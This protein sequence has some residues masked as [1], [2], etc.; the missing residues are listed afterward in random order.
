ME[1]LQVDYL[2]VIQIHDIEF[3]D[4]DQVLSSSCRCISA[5]SLCLYP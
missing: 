1:R 5:E 2:D 4:L 3:G